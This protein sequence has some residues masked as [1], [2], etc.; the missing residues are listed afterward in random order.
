LKAFEEAVGEETSRPTQSLR[1]ALVDHNIEVQQR[2]E[3][4]WIFRKT[5]INVHGNAL[6]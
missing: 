2:F 5:S 3:K 4:N 6:E 1:N